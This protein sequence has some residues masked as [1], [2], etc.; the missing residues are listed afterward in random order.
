MAKRPNRL[1]LS[2][3]GSFSSAKRILNSDVKQRLVYISEHISSG[4]VYGRNWLRREPQ[5]SALATATSSPHREWRAFGSTSLRSSSSRSLIWFCRFCSSDRHVE[6]R[7]RGTRSGKCEAD[8]LTLTPDFNARDP[9]SKS[10]FQ[11]PYRTPTLA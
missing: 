5:P 11:T 7:V 1:S 8:G 6:M 10:S 2:F 9:S 3:T 4:H